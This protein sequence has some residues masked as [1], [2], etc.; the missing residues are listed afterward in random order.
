MTDIKR[1]MIVRCPRSGTILLQ[2][3]LSAYKEVFHYPKHFHPVLCSPN[4]INTILVHKN[5]NIAFI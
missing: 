2:S 5:E 4:G 1:V 3:V